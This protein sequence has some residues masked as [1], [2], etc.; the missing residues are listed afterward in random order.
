MADAVNTELNKTTD[1]QFDFS[2][3]PRWNNRNRISFVY[4][5]MRV[6]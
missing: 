6:R 5:V 3:L 1:W 4:D 2:A